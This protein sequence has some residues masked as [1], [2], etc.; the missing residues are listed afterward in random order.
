[1][2]REQYEHLDLAI[3][4][5]SQL[6]S[7]LAKAGMPATP[8]YYKLTAIRETLERRLRRAKKPHKDGCLCPNCDTFK[9]YLKT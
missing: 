4:E 7:R 5:V 3:S 8:T 2:T 6:Q 9:P 1:M